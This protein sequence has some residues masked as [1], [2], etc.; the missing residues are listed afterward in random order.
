MNES[1]NKKD[2]FESHNLNMAS[3]DFKGFQKIYVICIALDC[4]K[5]V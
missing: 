3:T 1:L 5:H 2:G 4:R